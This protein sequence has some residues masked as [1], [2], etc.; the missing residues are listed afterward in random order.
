ML[1]LYFQVKFDFAANQLVLNSIHLQVIVNFAIVL[2]KLFQ[3]SVYNYSQKDILQCY[4]VD[5]QVLHRSDDQDSLKTFDQQLE[6]LLLQ[7]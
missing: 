4:I 3:L 5:F 6:S 7:D 2:A 1:K